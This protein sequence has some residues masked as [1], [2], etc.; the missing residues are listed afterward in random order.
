MSVASWN[1]LGL[2]CNSAIAP[3][4]DCFGTAEPAVRYDSPT[5]GGFRFETSYGTA[6]VVPEILRADDSR[7][8]GSGV[9]PRPA[10]NDSHFWDFAAFYT[11]DWNSIKVSAA[12]AF[13]WEQTNPLNGGRE[14]INQVGGSIMHKPSGLGIY[15]MGEW[16]NAGAAKA[17]CISGSSPQ[18]NQN[19]LI[20]P[21]GK[22]LLA[23]FGLNKNPFELADT[24]MWGIKPFWRKAWM[25]LGATVL[26]GEFAQYNDF[27]G[28]GNALGNAFSNSGAN[29][30]AAALPA[31]ANSG[32]DNGEGCAIT[33]SQVERWGLGVVQEIDSAAMHVWARWQHQDFKDF[34]MISV[35]QLNETGS[36]T[37]LKQGFD[38]WDLF[39][40]G[41]IIFF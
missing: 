9:T 37:K 22:D 26:Y 33:N 5:W 14:T 15:A 28:L 10:T 19:C 11:G 36:A 8:D 25:P 21:S 39:Q 23:R 29:G 41:A 13:T 40:V 31:C 4:A 30:P 1:A 2:L 3:G 7:I 12:Y 38:D 27:Y 34:S 24:S 17:S 6:S 35:D 16:E 20:T 32:L 18:N